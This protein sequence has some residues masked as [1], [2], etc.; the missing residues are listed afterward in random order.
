LTKE[1]QRILLPLLSAWGNDRYFA[2]VWYAVDVLPEAAGTA[3]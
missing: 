1:G 3:N 2:L